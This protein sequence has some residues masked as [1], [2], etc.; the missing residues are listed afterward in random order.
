MTSSSQDDFEFIFNEIATGSSL[1]RAIANN[2]A[3][4]LGA[5]LVEEEERALLR[6]WERVIA[7]FGQ[8][9]P[10]DTLYLLHNAI[11]E[12][13]LSTIDRLSHRNI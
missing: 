4:L 2:C 7:Y 11:I 8:E 5:L 13:D 9:F 1:V 3:R 12:E 10:V 6:T